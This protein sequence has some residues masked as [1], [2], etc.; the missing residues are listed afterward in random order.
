MLTFF[1]KVC[2]EPQGVVKLVDVDDGDDDVAPAGEAGLPTVAPVP[3]GSGRA[4]TIGR[5]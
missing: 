4:L 5:A 2:P 1:S 3:V